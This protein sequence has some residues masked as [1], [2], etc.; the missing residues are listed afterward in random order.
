MHVIDYVHDVRKKSDMWTVNVSMVGLLCLR[1]ITIL[2]CLARV[3]MIEL[4]VS[5][6][7][8]RS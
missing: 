1:V 6:N 7:V 2:A 4:N 5:R 3:V 8:T